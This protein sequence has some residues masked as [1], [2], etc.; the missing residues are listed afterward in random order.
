MT[1]DVVSSASSGI[2][3]CEPILQA[4][5]SLMRSAVLLR[6][7]G[8]MRELIARPMQRTLY[9]SLEHVMAQGVRKTHALGMLA[10]CTE[11]CSVS[12]HPGKQSWRVSKQLYERLRCEA[13]AYW[14]TV[15]YEAG[16]V[17]NELEV[18]DGAGSATVP[19]V[20]VVRVPG[21]AS[22]RAM[23][24]VRVSGTAKTGRKKA[25]ADPVQL[26]LLLWA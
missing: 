19:S 16:V 9:L 4:A 25:S 14:E 3:V 17:V 21:R 2:Y 13:I 12:L 5:R 24:V 22:S 1:S 6:Y 18:A 10:D 8:G 26:D 15:G 23:N 7:A 20:N 11:L